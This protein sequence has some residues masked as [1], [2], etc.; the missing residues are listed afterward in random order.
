LVSLKRMQR[1]R[2]G[3]LAPLRTSP[4]PA[5]PEVAPPDAYRAHGPYRTAQVVRVVHRWSEAS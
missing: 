3:A 1:R 2:G 5:K 4:K